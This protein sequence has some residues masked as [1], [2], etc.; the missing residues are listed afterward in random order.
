MTHDVKTVNRLHEC[1]FRVE[2]DEINQAVTLYERDALPGENFI[3]L[4]VYFG[5]PNEKFLEAIDAMKRT[6][7]SKIGS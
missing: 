1:L 7:V 5:E 3:A 6:V 2:R 4:L